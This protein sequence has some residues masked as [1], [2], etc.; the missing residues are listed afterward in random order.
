[1]TQLQCAILDDYQGVALRMADWSVLANQV[2]VTTFA[3]HIDTEA[4]LVR[5]L[6]PFQVV[7]A[8]RERT[9]FPGSVLRQLPQLQLL[10]TTGMRNAA[11]DVKAATTQGIVVCGTGSSSTPPVELTWALLLGLARQIVGE[12][13]AFRNQGPWQST[14]GTD[15]YGKQLGLVGLG[16]IG[17]RVA[18]VGL[19]FGM[20][21]V[22]WSPHLTLERAMECGVER[23]DS[24]E[25]LLG[26]SD[27][28]SL[29]LVLSDRTRGLIGAPELRRMRSSAYLINTARAGL[30]GS[31]A[32]VQALQQ[33]WIAGAGLDVFEQEPVPAQDLLRT[34]PNVLA[35]PHLGYVT[36]DN[37]T[38]YY[39]E[40]I[41]D[42]QAYINESPIRVL[43]VIS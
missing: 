38:T 29:H 19:A 39:R 33:R 34:L 4:E 5:V 14:V 13:Q 11:I 15:L 7:V 6:A 12:N 24:K 32:L 43:Q 31:V 9:P 30:V 8:M 37:Y 20:K 1:M 17:S 2:Q 23:A 35:T 16:K 10:I 22:A 25:E 3:Q 28:V 41:E 40:A 18:R 21:V 36:Q 27:F 26:Y 42:I